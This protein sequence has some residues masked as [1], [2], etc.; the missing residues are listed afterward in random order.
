METNEPKLLKRQRLLFVIIGLL[1]ITNLASLGY[2]FVQQGIAKEQEKLAVANAAKATEQANIANAERK[3][4][5][6]LAA[7]AMVQHKMAE[8]ATRE[9]LRELAITEAMTKAHK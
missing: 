4:A 8:E 5:E 7:E 9:A 1:V 6:A 2:A 3:K